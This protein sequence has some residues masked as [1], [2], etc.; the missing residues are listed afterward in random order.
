MLCIFILLSLRGEDW[1]VVGEKDLGLLVVWEG[2][3]GGR[4]GVWV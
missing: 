2:H 3:V 4:D 1:F